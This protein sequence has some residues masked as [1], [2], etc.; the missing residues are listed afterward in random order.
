MKQA[1]ALS[2]TSMIN[3]ISYCSKAQKENQPVNTDEKIGF[4]AGITVGSQDILLNQWE[5]K[6][7]HPEDSITIQAFKH[8]YNK[9]STLII[10]E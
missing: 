2:K 5:S 7:I 10:C 9:M 3:L 1:C 8:A 4:T 6:T